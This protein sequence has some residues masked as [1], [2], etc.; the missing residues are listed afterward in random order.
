[1]S[2]SISDDQ[3]LVVRVLENMSDACVIL[4]RSWRYTYVNQRA[5]ALFGRDPKT[6]V[7]KHIWTEFPEGVGQ[8]FHLAY[9]ASMADQQPRHIEAFYPPR[10]RWYENRICPSEDGLA[11][12]F[13]DVTERRLAESAERNLAAAREQAERMAHLGFWRWDFVS[14]RVTWSDELYRIYA[15]R[16]AEFGASFEAYLSLVHPD[17]RERVRKN[18]SAA[19]RDRRATSFAERILRP[20]GEVRYLHSWAAVSVDELGVAQEMFGTCLDLTELVETAA[21]LR[22]TEAWLARALSAARVGLW[23]WDRSTGQVQWSP[24]FEALFGVSAESF[25]SSYDDAIARVAEEDRAAVKAGIDAALKSGSGFRIEHRVRWPDGTVRWVASHGTIERDAAGVSTRMSGS[26]VDITALKEAQ[27]E[28]ERA[29]EALLHTQKLDAIGRLAAGVAHDIKNFLSIVDMSSV[30]L[31]QRVGDDPMLVELVSNI[32]QASARAATLTRQLLTLGGQQAPAL[33]ELD[34]AEVIGSMTPLLRAAVPPSVSLET[35]F[36]PAP[37]FGDRHQIEQLIVNLVMNARD[38]MPEGGT[39]TIATATDGDE[40]SMEVR[41]TGTG[42]T[43]DVQ[44][45]IF[46][47]FYTT[48]EHGSGVGMA[49]VRDLVAQSRGRIDVTSAVGAGTTVQVILPRA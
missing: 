43:P 15:I 1:M 32:H 28:R 40:V 23:D 42:M 17:D 9:E 47:P 24:G 16:P 19:L 36:D 25:G 26:V 3:A 11:I 38:A 20:G 41:D 18:L 27:E 48:R 45:R 22:R 33:S 14:D 7:G 5:G 46:E 2:Q 31:S 29:R 35:R 39:L 6:L 10:N 49:T 30:A 13:S 44:A 8:P 34:L 21:E 12:F 4:D 37:V